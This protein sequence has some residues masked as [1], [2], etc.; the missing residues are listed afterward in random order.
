MDCADKAKAPVLQLKINGQ[1]FNVGPDLY[2]VDGVS[3][4]EGFSIS[5]K[6]NIPK[7]LT[8]FQF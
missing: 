8:T 6:I 5:H 2:V 3:I 4:F 7:L 1:T